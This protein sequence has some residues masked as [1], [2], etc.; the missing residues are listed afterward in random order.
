LL[1]KSFGEAIVPTKARSTRLALAAFALAAAAGTG[2]AL[3]LGVQQAEAV[4]P[5]L[6]TLPLPTV[7]VPGVTTVAPPTTTG[8]TSTVTTAVTTTVAVPAPGD[9]PAAPPVTTTKTTVPP[10]PPPPGPTIAGAR[11]LAS[12]AV[13]IPVSSVHAPARLRLLVS[14]APHVLKQ[15]GQRIA[16]ALRVVDTRGYVVRG[17]RVVVGMAFAAH[18]ATRRVG[19]RLSA[20]DGLAT[21]TAPVRL[22]AKRPQLVVLVIGAIDPLA[23]RAAGA[24]LTLRVPIR[25]PR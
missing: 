22:P 13:S 25:M 1:V 15:K 21:F 6:P 23:P 8:S 20:I 3:S 17:A 24:S 18:G 19:M 14:F 7:T 9:P 16:V 10:P 11:R 4:G 12:G 2:A 5:T